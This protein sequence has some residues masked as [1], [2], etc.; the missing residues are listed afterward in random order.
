MAQ[1][2]EPLYLAPPPE[3][4]IIL[5]LIVNGVGHQASGNGHSPAKDK[6]GSHRGVLSSDQERLQGI[7]ES[8]VHSTVDEDTAGGDGESSVQTLDAIRLQSLDVDIDQSVELALTTLALGIVGQPG[9]GKVKGVHK[10]KGHGSSGATGGNVGGK[11]GGG[12]QGL[13]GVLEGKV[14]CLGGEVTQHVGEVSSP[15]RNNAFGGQH[16]LGAVK[17]SGVRLVQT[18]LLDHL[19]LVLD[20]KL[21]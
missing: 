9:P 2:M 7:K 10:Q 19:I 15:E 11:L 8:E 3:V 16:S 4:I 5:L 20:E 17:D 21:D 1:S 14:K 12:E 13:D 6:G 18:T